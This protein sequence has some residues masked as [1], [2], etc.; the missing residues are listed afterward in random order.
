MRQIDSA[1]YLDPAYPMLPR[2]LQKAGYHTMHIGKWHLSEWLHRNPE[3]PR[4]DA[5]GFSEY[6]L[7]YLNWPETEYGDRWTQATH[8]ARSSELFVDE[9]INF[10]ERRHD[11]EQPFFLQLWMN[12]PHVPLIPEK[13]Q[14]RYYD[15]MPV[16]QPYNQNPDLDPYRIYWNTLTEMDK[17][18]G[19]LFKRVRES[20]LSENTYIIFT[21][22]NG[23]PDPLSYNYYVGMGSNGPFRGE[24]GTLY[25]GGI[26][27]PLIVWHPARVPAGRVD[28][29]SILCLTDLLPTLAELGGAESPSKLDGEPIQEVWHGGTLNQRKRPLMWEWRYGQ[30]RGYVNRSP[31]LAIRDGDWK[32]LINPDFSRI[33]L[34][35]IPDDPIE[36]NNFAESK[37]D[38]VKRLEKALL[39]F[40]KSLPGEVVDPNAGTVNYPWP[41]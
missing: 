24:K 30:P 32:L 28:D 3:L 19:R 9:A 41:R 6:L 23:A 34:Y 20:G 22:D 31:M 1:R 14:M 35:R 27:V 37:P 7:A 11:S 18:L 38:I 2:V 29:R 26:R 4:P 13:K 10:L 12:D 25:E 16:R 8:R 33:E 39:D 36:T 17:Q 5:Y 15:E 40:H 21:S